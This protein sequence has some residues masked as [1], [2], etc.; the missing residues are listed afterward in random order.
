MSDVETA[1]TGAPAAPAETPQAQEQVQPSATEQEAQPQEQ[2]RDEKGRF[3]PQERFNEVY[4][5]RR[6]AERERDFYRQQL[7]QQSATQPQHAPH[8]NDIP[9]IDS[10]Q[11]AEEWGAALAEYSARQALAKAEEKFAQH[12]QQRHRSQIAQQFTVKEAEFAATV[13]DYM[14]RV[15]ELGAV[16]P[17]SAEVLEAIALSDHGPA[18]AY[19]LA[20]HLEEADQISRLPPHIAAVRIGRIEAQLSAPKPKPVSQA[21]SPVPTVGGGSTVPKDP[22]R[23]SIEEWT[24]WR[25]SQLRK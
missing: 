9:R 23:M 5:L 24:A 18:I 13:P 11:T 2:P 1:Q 17:L 19:H 15:E 16:V 7:A 20:Q 22:E 14:E 12:D 8:G 4:R 10:F 25:N 3:V 6:E 21:P